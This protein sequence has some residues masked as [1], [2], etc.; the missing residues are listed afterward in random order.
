MK[1]D[2]YKYLRDVVDEGFSLAAFFTDDYIGHY[3]HRQK[4]KNDEGN[5]QKKET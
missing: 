5:N 2:K 3:K 4:F 1:R